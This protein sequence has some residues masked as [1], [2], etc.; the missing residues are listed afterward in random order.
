M[1]YDGVCYLIEPVYSVE[2]KACAYGLCVLAFY[3]G[4]VHVEYHCEYEY[5]G[6]VE[7]VGAPYDYG[8]NEVFSRLRTV[9]PKSERH[10]DSSLNKCRKK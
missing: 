3:Q 10:I 4:P 8:V 1:A 6:P 7:I 5:E 2:G 9:S